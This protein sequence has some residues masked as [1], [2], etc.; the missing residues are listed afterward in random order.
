MPPKQEELKYK[1]Y[2]IIYHKIIINNMIIDV[3][4]ETVSFVYLQPKQK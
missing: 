1:I 4:E 2:K 3:P